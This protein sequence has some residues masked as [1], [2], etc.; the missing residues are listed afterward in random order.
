MLYATSTMM[1]TVIQGRW[2]HDV[3]LL[4][5]E[6][7][8]GTTD[9]LLSLLAVCG[10]ALVTVSSDPSPPV[11]ARIQASWPASPLVV[12]ILCVFAVGAP[13]V[14]VSLCIQGPTLDPYS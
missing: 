1:M 3:E 9:M 4:R 8:T 6:P 13:S 10:A 5:V 2:Q 14:R 11:V 12:Q 7:S